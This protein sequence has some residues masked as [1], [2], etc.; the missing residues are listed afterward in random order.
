MAVWDERFGTRQSAIAE[1]EKALELRPDW[2]DAHKRLDN[3]R[4]VKPATRAMPTTD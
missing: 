4:S 1:F 2:P 3:L